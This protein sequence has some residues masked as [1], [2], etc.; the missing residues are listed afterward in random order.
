MKI[1]LTI[2]LAAILAIAV[3]PAAC[4]P[5]VGN[6]TTAT[7]IF[8]AS[9]NVLY[10]DSVKGNDSTRRP[11]KTLNAA[12]TAAAAGQLVYVFPG[13]YYGTNLGKDKVNWHFCPGVS[14][15]NT[16]GDYIFADNEPLATTTNSMEFDIS[17]HVVTTNSFFGYFKGPRTKVKIC[18]DTIKRPPADGANLYMLANTYAHPEWDGTIDQRMEL[19]ARELAGNVWLGE[20]GASFDVDLYTNVYFYLDHDTLAPNPPIV[21][22]GREALYCD[23]ICQRTHRSQVVFDIPYFTGRPTN[24]CQLANNSTATRGFIGYALLGEL[25]FNNTVFKQHP[26]GRLFAAGAPIMQEGSYAAMDWTNA[27][28]LV[29]NNCSVVGSAGGTN[30]LVQRCDEAATTNKASVQISALTYCN[31]FLEPGFSFG[32]GGALVLD[33]SLSTRYLGTTQSTNPPSLLSAGGLFSLTNSVTTGANTNNWFALS[34]S[35]VASL[36]IRS[37]TWRIGDTYR[38]DAALIVAPVSGSTFDMG[39]YL[40]GQQI[41]VNESMPDSS[42]SCAMAVTMTYVGGGK[43][44]VSYTTHDLTLPFYPREVTEFT[45]DPAVDNT[46]SLFGKFSASDPNNQASV[47]QLLLWKVY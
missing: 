3:I 11:F 16:N 39:V 44:K 46:M 6:V 43:L 8:N 35:G 12:N 10:V 2:L 18:A 24:D 5:V 21:F 45:I 32:G 26:N 7:S 17:G 38:L 4:A 40:G 42:I 33:D 29:F 31:A 36:T 25:V 30:W 15:E 19:K 23:I 27:G 14:L 22:K 47:S 37:N 28:S 1:K 13:V 9:T 34:Y 20:C 41:A